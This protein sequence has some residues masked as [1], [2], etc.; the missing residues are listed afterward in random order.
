MILYH[1]RIVWLALRWWLFERHRAPA[2]TSVTVL[3]CWPTECDINWHLNNSQYLAA[4]DLGRWHFVLQSGLFGTFWRDRL[5]PMAV[6]VEIDYKRS[7]RPLQRY[8]I[9]TAIERVGTK[10]TTFLQRFVAGDSVAAEARV[11]VV[12]VREGK[13][14]EVG[15]VLPRLSNLGPIQALQRQDEFSG[16]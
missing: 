7:I 13:S 5:F 4:M 9:E 10:S 12:L 2:S 6:R 14:V 15:E 16:R 8:R 3:R 11:I 1:L